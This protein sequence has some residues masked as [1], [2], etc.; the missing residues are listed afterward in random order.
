MSAG[1]TGAVV[2][3]SSRLFQRLEGVDK[4]APQLYIP[5]ERPMDQND[6]LRCYLSWSNITCASKRFCV[7]ATGSGATLFQKIP[8]QSDVV[9]QWC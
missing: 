4:A 2:V 6:P 1:N 3:A 9:V 7:C 5:L 8:T